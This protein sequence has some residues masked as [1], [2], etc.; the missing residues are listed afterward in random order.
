MSN[1]QP[2]FDYYWDPHQQLRER[3]ALCWLCWRRAFRVSKSTGRNDFLRVRSRCTACST[4]SSDVAFFSG[5]GRTCYRA[6]QGYNIYKICPIR[7]FFFYFSRHFRH[8]GGLIN[9]NQLRLKKRERHIRWVD[10]VVPLPEHP[11]NHA[12]LQWVNSSDSTPLPWPCT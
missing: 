3:L 7:C 10:P 11:T 5:W 6:L 9:D 12:R 4:G 1:I 8:S 2:I